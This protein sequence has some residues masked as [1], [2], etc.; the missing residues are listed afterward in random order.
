[1]CILVL[2]R[3]V[4]NRVYPC[5][6]SIPIQNPFMYVHK[7]LLFDEPFCGDATEKSRNLA[8]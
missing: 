7:I 2:V 1:M 8:L 6:E 3:I 4:F 5:F